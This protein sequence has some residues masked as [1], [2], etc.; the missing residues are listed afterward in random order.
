M[1]LVLEN[2]SKNFATVNALQDVS[3]TLPHNSIT[4]LLGP[5]GAG[6][7]T[8]QKIVAGL[9]YPDTG[10]ISFNGQELNTKTGVFW[11]LGYV[12]DEETWPGGH[13]TVKEFLILVARL[14]RCPAIDSEIEAIVDRLNLASVLKR[15][16]DTLSL[17]FKQRVQL[18]QALIGDP[19]VLL[20]DEPGNGLDP[21][22]F[23][24]LEEILL[25]EKSKRIILIST[26][27][28]RDCEKIA[29]RV[30]VLNQGRLSQVI[31]KEDW[32]RTIEKN[33]L[34]I[35]LES[36]DFILTDFLDKETIQ[37]IRHTD[38][39]QVIL[40]KPES[41]SEILSLLNQNG[42]IPRLWE[43]GHI[44]SLEDWFFTSLG[45]ESA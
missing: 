38:W 44:N 31:Q 9:I 10:Q 26:H 2:I 27:R 28:I 43:L 21:K 18:A 14:K 45:K 6:K 20:L 12:S 36:S 16:I 11:K 15:R 42:L 30:A 13:T 41:A 37:Y 8:L 33:H 39:I 7:T 25:L 29:D 19:E 35:A 40:P 22:Q 17:G 1:A 4:L 34:K 24:E 23:Q 32:Q 3:L 5:N